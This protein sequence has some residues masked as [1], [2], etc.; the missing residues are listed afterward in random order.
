ML[1]VFHKNGLSC[2]QYDELYIKENQFTVNIN[3]TYISSGKREK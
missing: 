1:L 3:A 2:K